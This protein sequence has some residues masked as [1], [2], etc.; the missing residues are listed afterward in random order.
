MCCLSLSFL[1]GY[2]GVWPCLALF[3]ALDSELRIAEG[4]RVPV[5]R[6]D[7]HVAIKWLLYPLLPLTSR[8]AQLRGPTLVVTE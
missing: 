8:H 6:L 1:W 5:D 2:S 3:C 4:T 7:I